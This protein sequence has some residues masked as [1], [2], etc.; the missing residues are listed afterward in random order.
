MKKLFTLLSI[1][2]F[3]SSIAIAQDTIFLKKARFNPKSERYKVVTDRA[4]QAVFLELGNEVPDVT[5]FYDRRFSKTVDGLGFKIGLGKSVED[6]ENGISFS[7]GLNYLVG[8]NK[9]GRFLEMS[10][11]QTIYTRPYQTSTNSSFS[12]YY[13]SR[14]TPN[15][16][17]FSIG[18]RSQPLLGGFNFRGGISPIVLNGYDLFTAYFSLGLNF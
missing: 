16:T 12:S 8:N 18:Y 10:L 4:P 5:V 6:Y 9:K 14:G 17:Q 7:G 1:T 3:S 13:F 15:I 2:L 11:T